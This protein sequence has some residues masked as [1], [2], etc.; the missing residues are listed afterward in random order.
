MAP[1]PAAAA[2]WVM[3]KMPRTQP[4]TDPETLL[5]KIGTELQW[6]ASDEEAQEKAERWR[7]AFLKRL[8][9]MIN[10]PERRGRPTRFE[11]SNSRDDMIQG[12]CYEEDSHSDALRESKIRRRHM[13]TYLEFIRTLTGR[14]FE[15]VCRGLLALLGCE[16]PVL[17]PKGNDQ[18]IDFHGRIQ[19]RGRLNMQYVQTAV[20][21]AM[22]TWIVGQAKQIEG[23]VSTPEIRDLIGA[24][25]MARLG[26]SADEGQALRELGMRPY[27]SVWRFFITTG[28]FSRDALKLINRLGL[29]GLDGDMV[30]SILADHEVANVAGVCDPDAFAAWVA[31]HLPA[32]G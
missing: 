5:V 6:F 28:S 17:T 26:I 15:G 11:F 4:P 2:D 9:F 14:Q 30:A 25:E 21:E 8:R 27:D 12:S 24:V 1:G 29:L 10:D 20:D 23:T 19:M 31:S 32:D 3:T 16:D 13:D 18:G 7:T 22:H